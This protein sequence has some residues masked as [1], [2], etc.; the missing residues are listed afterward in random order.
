MN[1][2]IVGYGVVGH[3]LAEIFERGSDPVVIYDKYLDAYSGAERKEE[4][5]S[6]RIVF[7]AV[8]TPA[9][10]DGSCD[11][12]AIEDAV[13]WIE[14][15]ICIKSTIPPLTTN[16]LVAATGKRIVF[17]PEYVGETPF[18]KYKTFQIP[19]VVVVGG[20]RELCAVVTSAYRDI[21]GPNP[22]YFETSAITAE[23]AKYMENCFFAAKVSFVAQFFQLAA[24]FGAD[25]TQMREIWV[26][27]TRVGRSHS[28]IIGDLGFGGRCLPKDLAAIIHRAME[29]GAPVE[30]LRAI[31]MFNDTV[32][33]DKCRR[34]I[35]MESC[36]PTVKEGDH[37][38]LVVSAD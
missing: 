21:L 10:S 23:L 33:S 17:S 6:C 14:R 5:N 12:S 9:R 24:S 37:E 20:E 4:I 16:G 25:F 13:G 15:P 34:A 32:H 3:H 8:P 38:T 36:D 35:G 30:L 28:T 29:V 31:Q 27:D 19:D 7:V 22:Q 26:A 18:H 1:I 2:G 11:I